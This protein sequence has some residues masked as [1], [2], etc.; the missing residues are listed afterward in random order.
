MDEDPSERLTGYICPRCGGALS[1]RTNGRGQDDEYQCRIGHA[2]TAA[3]VWIEHCAMRNRALGA[4]ARTLAENADLARALAEQARS[5]G[6]GSLA[7]R[8]EDEARAEEQHIGTILEMLEEIGA[9]DAEA[10]LGSGR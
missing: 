6:D 10:D 2:F 8:L 7:A 5:L 3:E 4:A 1:R 9:G